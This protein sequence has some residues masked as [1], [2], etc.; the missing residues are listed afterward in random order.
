MHLLLAWIVALAA[1]IAPQRTWSP[2]AGPSL[3]GGTPAPPLAYSVGAAF[4]SARS[5]LVVFGGSRLGG[6]SGEDVGVGRQ[7]LAPR[8]EPRPDAAQRTGHVLRLAA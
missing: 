6:Y 4:D 7:G 8:V 3:R 1:V 2:D 5:V